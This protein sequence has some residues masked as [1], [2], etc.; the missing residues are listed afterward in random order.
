MIRVREAIVV[1]GKYDKIKLSSLVEGVII[2]VGGFGLFKDREKLRYLRELAEK[3]GLIVLTDSD[4]AGF[5]IRHKLS[6]CIP[7]D[8]LKHAYIPD[9][10]GK[11]RRKSAPSKEGKLGVEGMELS[12]LRQALEK[13][14]ATLEDA[15]GKGESRPPAGSFTKAD[16]FDWGLA[17]R[18]DSAGRRKDLQR[19]LGL[20][21]RLSANGLLQA[22]NALYSREELEAFLKKGGTVNGSDERDAAASGVPNQGQVVSGPGGGRF[23]G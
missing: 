22:L 2:E 16:L 6:S 21:E 18:P 14:G 12:V 7:P 19:R 8:R 17:G 23:S 11:E 4:G 5:L 10:L 15:S 13:A 3:R 20:P 9:I 1:E